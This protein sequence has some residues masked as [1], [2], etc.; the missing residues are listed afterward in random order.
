MKQDEAN[1]RTN[2]MKTNKVRNNQIKETVVKIQFLKNLKEF[3]HFS[4]IMLISVYY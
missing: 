2:K 4:S 1:K 3:L